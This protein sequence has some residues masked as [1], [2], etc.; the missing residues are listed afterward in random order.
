MPPGQDCKYFE[1]AAF[2]HAILR[3][4]FAMILGLA[5]SSAPQSSRE[6]R[7]QRKMK[8][9]FICF[10]ED[11]HNDTRTFEITTLRLW[12]LEHYNVIFEKLTKNYG[13]FEGV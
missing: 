9:V 8:Y 10:R 13:A 2:I 12:C 6:S 1:V 11:L 5:K 4:G 7:A 3:G